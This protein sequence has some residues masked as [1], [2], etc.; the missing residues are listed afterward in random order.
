MSGSGRGRLISIESVEFFVRNVTMWVPFRY[1]KA[2]L[3]AAPLLHAR[4][5]ARD[6]QG[7]TAYGVSADMLPPKWFDKSADKTYRR[8]ISDLILAAKLGAQTYC[9]VGSR[10][11]TPFELW[12]EACD[13][14]LESGPFV[15][16]NALTSSFGSSIVERALL[17]AAGKLAGADLHTMLREN[18]LGI[19]PEAVHAELAGRRL[20]DS[21]GPEP[22]EGLYIRHT[23]GLSDPIRDED[24]AP[25]DRRNDGIPQ[26][27]EAWIREAGVRYFKIKISAGI[28]AD[29]S[30]LLTVA[31][32]LDHALNGTYRV[33]LDGNEQFANASELADW[34]RALRVEAGLSTLFERILFIEQPIERSAALSRETTRCLKEASELPPVILDESD[35]ELDAF[36]RGVELGY[37]GISVKNCKGVLKGLL[38][39]MLVD[40]FN[41][42]DGGR[43]ILSSEDLCNQPIVA[44]QQDLCTLSVLGVE[45]A[46][47][48]GHHYC[49]TLDHVSEGELAACLDVHEALYET[50]RAGARLRIRDGRIDLRSLRQPGLGV[51]M[52]TD[53]AHMTPIADWEYES[54]GI[55]G[56]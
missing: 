42:P 4:L 8:N 31:A 19:V 40:L 22:C 49:G 46:E 51:G 10:W 18:L 13:L 20:A 55:E 53:F 34:H 15:G 23:V 43:Y 54:L 33:T 41:A 11:R 38:N 36:K 2:C 6:E 29:R 56:E 25:G 32:M 17:D 48:N 47:R 7:H 12:H 27:L 39:K 44:L 1:G 26:S 45:H 30:R 9:E 35:G 21:I 28:D 14:L 52:E 16:L 50:H 3:V 37:R 5:K 24:I